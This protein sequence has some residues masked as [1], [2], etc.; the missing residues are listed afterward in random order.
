MVEAIV[1]DRLPDLS[2]VQ[3]R[4]LA[5]VVSRLLISYAVSAPDDPPE[6]VAAS[7]AALLTEGAIS[8]ALPR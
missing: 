8:G 3:V 6:I 5:D 7:V 2:A 1:S 4:R